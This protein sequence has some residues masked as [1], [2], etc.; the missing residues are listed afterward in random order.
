MENPSSSVVAPA[1]AARNLAQADNRWGAALLLGCSAYLYANLFA[2]PRTPFLL[3]GDQAFFWMRAQRLLYGEQIYRDFL[4]FTPPGTDLTYLGFFRLFGPRIWVPN[5]VVLLLGVG[6]CWVCWLIARSLMS[7]AQALLAVALFVVLVYGKLINGTQHW[8]SV[9]AVLS[10]VAVLMKA[11]T[12]ARIVAAGA[13]LG[14]ATFY[15][16][17][18]GPLAALAIAACVMWERSRQGESWSGQMRSLVRL[19]APLV[20]T[21]SCL[22]GYYLVTIGWRTLWFF[23]VTYV[24]RYAINSWQADS[25]G[26]PTA[27]SWSALPDAFRPVFACGVIP[28]VYLVSLWLCSRSI[29]R[30]E[31]SDNA[32]RIL[33]VA[34]VGAAMFIEIVP[35]PSW[36]RFYCVA[37][38]AVILL[39]W[40]AGRAGNLAAPLERIAWVGVIALGALQITGRHVAQSMTGE[41]PAGRV[42]TTPAAAGKL[43]WL[44]AH[45]HPGQ[46]VL[47]AGWLS[48]Y[49]PLA[50]RNPVFVDYLESAAQ[51]RLGYLTLSIRELQA[52][53]VQYVL[54]SPRLD[55]PASGLGLFRNFLERHY[56]LVWTFSDQDQVWERK[57]EGSDS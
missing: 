32:A 48:I 55:A 10:A 16:Q 23:Q 22:I 51:D 4:E 33:L 52:K 37:A 29:Q 26:W 2:D 27:F 15:L 50:V 3:G 18:R 1:P 36:F 17:T 47:Q 45:T 44:A 12:P 20:I 39:P 35:S 46:F 38:P 31:P 30:R 7:R 56:R 40:L 41:L 34:A 11:R 14:V 24:R 42:A 13:L 8:F 5:L 25:L 6:L 54:W 9:L 21:W 43:G 53:Q 28:A 49:L 19:F 57:P